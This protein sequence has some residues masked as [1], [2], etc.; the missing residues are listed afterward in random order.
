MWIFAN[1]KDER[2]LT[3]IIADGITSGLMKKGISI[4][5]REN[6]ALVEA[7]H[8]FQMSGS[9][10]DNDFVS[11]GHAAG[12]NTLVTVAVTGTS[13]LRRLQLRVLDIGRRTNLYQSDASDNWKL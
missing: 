13:S 5:D 1:S 11:I 12:A 10:S 2:I 8:Q 7:E 6:S 3:G 9:V 4:V